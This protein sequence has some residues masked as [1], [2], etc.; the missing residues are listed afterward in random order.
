MQLISAGEIRKIDLTDDA[1]V[2]IKARDAVEFQ[3][4][5][6]RH[7]IALDKLTE[8]GADLN[9]YLFVDKGKDQKV[10]YISIAPQRTLK[11]DFDKDGNGDMFVGFGGFVTKDIAKVVFDK[12]PLGIDNNGIIT[13]MVIS[14]VN[15]RYN[16]SKYIHWFF[17]SI[18]IILLFL[19][20]YFKGIEITKEK[21]D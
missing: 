15:L 9:V 8:K 7:I 5:G 21:E 10:S 11:L 17:G 3:M 12:L 18:I 6:G 14:E 1:I 13:G 4:Y 16:T 20:L 19:V 2:E